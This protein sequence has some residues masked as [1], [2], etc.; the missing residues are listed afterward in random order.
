MN[1]GLWLRATFTVAGG[2]MQDAFVVSMKYA[3]KCPQEYI[4]VVFSVTGLAALPWIIT[5][6]TIPRRLWSYCSSL[7]EM[8]AIVVVCGVGGPLLTGAIILSKNAPGFH[9]EEWEATKRRPKNYLCIGS[10]VSFAALM[11]AGSA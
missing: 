5:V 2:A 11:I 7:V 10:L 4:W 9:A 6:P 1:E 8:L 3:H